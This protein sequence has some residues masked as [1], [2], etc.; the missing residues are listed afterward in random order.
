M[1][2]LFNSPAP[3]YNC[4]GG[5]DAV[6]TLS[7][8]RILKRSRHLPLPYIQ[9]FLAIDSSQLHTRIH[10]SR[11]PTPL[12]AIVSYRIHVRRRQRRYAFSENSDNASLLRQIYLWIVRA[13]FRSRPPQSDSES[14]LSDTE[15]T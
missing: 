11:P 4:N 15:L 12:M 3:P 7:R 6:R 5:W 10:K 14:A 2:N 9:P 13:I 8:P 1:N